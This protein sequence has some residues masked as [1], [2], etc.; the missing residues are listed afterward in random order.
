MRLIIFKY[1]SLFCGTVEKEF[2]LLRSF[3]IVQMCPTTFF[4]FWE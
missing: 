1:K 3:S 4:L 2:A